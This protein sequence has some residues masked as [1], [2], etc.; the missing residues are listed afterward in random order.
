MPG[1]TI[2]DQVRSAMNL[3]GQAMF[4]DGR[5]FPSQDPLRIGRRR[6]HFIAREIA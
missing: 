3:V 1:G 2:A 4:Y 5:R 6:S